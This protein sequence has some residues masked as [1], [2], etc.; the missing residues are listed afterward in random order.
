M[1]RPDRRG[2]LRR[3]VGWLGL[4]GTRFRTRA[5]ATAPGRIGASVAGVAVAVGLLLVVTGLALGMVAPAS[6]FGGDEY[7]ITPETDADS[8]LVSAGDPQFGSATEATERI[9]G[10]DGVESVS[11]V[12]IDHL[13]V[14][15]VRGE[16][17]RVIVVGVDPEAD[18]DVYGLSPSAIDSP[19]DVVVS[20]GTASTLDVEPDDS[21][22]LADYDRTVTVA[23]VDEGS[24]PAVAAPT[25]LV[26]LATLQS[27]TGA[28]EHDAADRFVVE[29]SSG[30]ESDLATVYDRS[31]VSTGSGLAADRLFAADLPLAL[32]LAA[33][34]VSVL[35]GTL[36]VAVVT[37]MEVAADREVLATLSAIGIPRRRRIGLY[38]GQSMLVSLSGGVVGAALGL[39]GIALANRASSALVEVTGPIVAHPLLVPYGLGASFVV[40]VVSIPVVWVTVHR[41]EAEVRPSG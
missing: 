39:G 31:T 20:A 3:T 34:L 1:D 25:L 6:G 28:D 8:P 5:T 23:G 9:R 41:V 14:E 40:G 16:R 32:S 11:P 2:R 18:I 7:W 21:L 27:L 30:I 24:G 26:D 19:S 38:A 13:V 10:M 33:L 35:V 22:A 37:A 29:G 4:V 36:F 17:T 12:L 15:T